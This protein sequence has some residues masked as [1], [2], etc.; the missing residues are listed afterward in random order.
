MFL[1]VNGIAST[2]LLGDVNLDGLV[3]LLDVTPFVDLLTS[4]GYLAEADVNTDGVVNLLDV[5]P[6]VDL[7]TGG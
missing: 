7:L 3:N 5:G 6:F 1:Q 2:V 4:S